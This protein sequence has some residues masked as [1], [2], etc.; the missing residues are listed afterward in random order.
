MSEIFKEIRRCLPIQQTV[1][2]FGYS[3]NRSGFT[4]SPFGK[5]K[6]PSCKLYHT[7]N[8][9][10]GFSANIG[11][12]CIKFA[13]AVLGVDNWQACQYL[14]EAFSLPFSLSGSIEN[15]AE[16]ER[17]K[18]DQERQRMREQEFK[19]AWRKEVAFLKWWEGV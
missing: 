15:Q 4:L 5:E 7:T 2:H 13:A 18:V 11:G 8:T 16:I 3:V 6:T 1:E 9:F 17:R 10:Y 14:I 12:D 19:A